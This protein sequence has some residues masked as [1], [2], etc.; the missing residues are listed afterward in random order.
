M[1]LYGLECGI[2]FA[3]IS[4]QRRIWHR[5]LA[6]FLKLTVDV[7]CLCASLG[8]LCGVVTLWQALQIKCICIS[9]VIG[10][11]GQ[12]LCIIFLL[13]EPVL[14]SK[15]SESISEQCT[16]FTCKRRND[17][18]QTKQVCFVCALL[19]TGMPSSSFQ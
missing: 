19:Y 16:L 3:Q 11:I 1:S 9:N 14:K 12:S 4:T 7:A 15:V 8:M 5:C 13:H 6:Q 2:G 17:P 18:P 10:W